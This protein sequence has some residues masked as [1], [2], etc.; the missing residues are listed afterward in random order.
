MDFLATCASHRNSAI[1]PSRRRSV[2]EF[3]TLCTVTACSMRSAV[4]SVRAAENA[5][6]SRQID[7]ARQSSE[8]IAHRELEE[9]FIDMLL[10]TSNRDFYVVASQPSLEVGWT[11]SAKTRLTSDRRSEGIGQRES[12]EHITRREGQKVIRID[13]ENLGCVPASNAATTRMQ[14]NETHALS[15]PSAWKRWGARKSSSRPS[16]SS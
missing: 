11:K 9:T 14:V 3:S 13:R 2:S 15:S 16:V 5:F 10:Q 6:G 8:D 7:T 12:L 1:I 4:Y